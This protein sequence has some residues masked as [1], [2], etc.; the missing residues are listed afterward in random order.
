M[1]N[2]L[3]TRPLYVGLLYLALVPAFGI[4]YYLNP[5]FWEEPLSVVQSIYFSVVT[6]TTLGYGDITPMTDLARALTATEAIVGVLVI[7]VFLNAVAQSAERNREERHKTT[8][9]EHLR[10]QYRELREDLVKACLRAEEGSYSVDCELEE[11]LVDFIEFRS[12]FS[13]EGRNRWYSVLNGMQRDEKIIEDVFLL[14]ELFSQQITVALGSVYTTN[15]EALGTL[16]RVAQHPR[17][18]QRLDIYS[19]DPVKYIGQFLFELLAM[20][21]SVSGMMERDFVDDAIQSL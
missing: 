14:C 4:V 3:L 21:S 12:Y 17:L 20:W 18:L 13:G 16:T 7:G 8:T 11:K 19:A 9:K 10:A 2:Q 5:A 6:I 15:K 1:L